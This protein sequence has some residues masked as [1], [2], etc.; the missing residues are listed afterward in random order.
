MVAG[1]LVAFALLLRVADPFAFR[2][3]GA[4]VLDVRQI[5]AFL[6]AWGLHVGAYV[7]ILTGTALAYWREGPARARS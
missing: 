5:D 7:G 6:T 1:A 3:A 4:D 2:T